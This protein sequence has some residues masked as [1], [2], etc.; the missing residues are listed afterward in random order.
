MP[1]DLR[2]LSKQERFCFDT[3]NNVVKF[4]DGYNEDRDKGQIAG[5][6]DRLEGLFENFLK[7]RL[8][9]DLLQDADSATAANDEEASRK[10]REQFEK[11][12]VKVK[13]FLINAERMA[14]ATPSVSTEVIAANSNPSRT[15]QMARIKLP[16]VKLPSFD[17]SVTDWLTFRDTFKSLI[18]S[19][20]NLSDVDK[21]SYLVA[22]LTKE[23]K[24]VVEAIDITEANYPI[25]WETLARRFDNKKL[26]VKTYLDALL[27]VE[28]L[29]RESYESLSRL[30]DD[31]D[32]NLQMIQ[33]M[34]IDTAG[35]SVLLAYIVCSCL[36]ASTLKQWEN[37]HKSTEVPQYEQLIEF[38][39]SHC[40]VLQSIA[41]GKPRTSEASR[42]DVV[43][44]QKSKVSS[45]HSVISSTLKSCGFCNQ[46]IHSPFKCEMFRKLS[47][48]ERFDLVKKRSL[49]INC[50]STDHQ[51]KN[52]SSGACRV[53]NQKHHT[54]LH[55][56][57]PIRNSAHPNVSKLHQNQPTTSQTQSQFQTA[58]TAPPNANKTS[59]QSPP[60]ESQ[61]LATGSLSYCSTSLAANF[62]RIP[63]TVLLQTA[64]VKVVGSSRNI[65]WA[66]ALLDPAS[67]LNI[68]SENLAQRLQLSKVKDHHTIGGIGKST[69]VSTHSITAEIQSHCCNYRTQLK[70]HVLSSVT[71]E[72][73]SN[74][75]EV[76][77]WHWPNDIV[78]A[79]PQFNEPGV[80]DMIIGVDS[81][82]DLLLDGFIRLGAGQPVLQNT[83]LGW[84][85]SGRAGVN[86][87]EPEI[88]S[89]VHVCTQDFDEKLSRFWELEACQSSSTMSVEEST[90]EAHFVATTARDTSGRFMVALP[91]KPSVISLMGNSYEI[92][93]RRF[94]SLERRLQTNPQLKSAY[95]A[96]IEEYRL[97]GH[98]KEITDIK[99]PTQYT[100]YY[101]PHHCIERPDSLTTKLRVVFDASCA[102]DTG[103]SLNNTLMVGP[104]VQDDLVSLILRWRIHRY[105]IIADIEKMYR[106]ILMN[107][108]FQCLQRILW[109]DDPSGPILIFELTTVTYGT[110]SAPYLATRCLY[111]LSKEGHYSNPYAAKVVGKDFNMDDLLTGCNDVE[112]GKILC[113]QLLQL[114]GSAGF[115][116]RKWSSN[117][118]EILAH[119]P[120]PLRDERNVLGL[121]PGASIKTLGLRWEP[122]SD[123]LGF[124]VP[125]WKE[126]HHI[127]KRIVASDTASLFDPP[128]FLGP[129]I[130]VAKLFVQELWRSNRS[131]DEPLED[132]IQQR[133]LLFRS[134]LAVIENLTVP[135]WVIPIVNPTHIE[136]HGFCDASERAYGACIYLRAVS[137]NGDTSVRLLT[138]KSKLAPLGNTPKQKKS[139]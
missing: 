124:H 60:A 14:N 43:K 48:P 63:S 123:V 57:A 20:P 19:N 33:K 70:F 126:N 91:I 99:L 121:D 135:R 40:I 93:K 111:E 28:P 130:V 128:G 82:Y 101:F 110:S 2:A 22:S 87:P 12:Y 30:I 134:Q 45:V 114:L 106:Q 136:L 18:D 120:Q 46:S 86:R 27:S 41:P 94:L 79:D 119:I 23:A 77:E 139:V 74:N 105:V 54:M 61:Q 3:L 10:I 83:L 35:W 56:Q 69:I 104:V 73:P 138:S 32:R 113:T 55:Q 95:S 78:L 21:F 6:K 26:V 8:Q 5:W 9:I 118:P 25:A 39:R 47:V 115:Q 4:V 58:Q 133:W 64:L 13:G 81:Y 98:M 59:S 17:G 109:R 108:A 68:I 122:A 52:C 7:I 96:F 90:C 103:I 51:I 75:I 84:V 15:N 1:A 42:S 66:R 127:T 31:F 49:C 131:W 107:P 100:P 76:T 24:R 129:I 38:L 125:K 36:D 62:H 67:Q 44:V 11:G 102:T 50:L 16:E 117:S 92:A 80:V 72:L 71:R 53:C 132:E 97:L 116:L 85:V 37:H 34:N 29:K 112:A 89:I 137:S 65:M 88:V